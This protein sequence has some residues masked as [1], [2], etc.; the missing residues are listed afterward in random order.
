MEVKHIWK[1][2]L[3]TVDP[4]PKN[5]IKKSQEKGE[6]SKI[7]APEFPFYGSSNPQT[8]AKADFLLSTF[9]FFSDEETPSNRGDASL[10]V[11]KLEQAALCR[12][13]ATYEIG[14]PD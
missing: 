3:Q 10:P 8:G 7:E 11:Q 5:Y 6:G 13:F 12:T 1:E 9:S 2:K 14:V 4:E